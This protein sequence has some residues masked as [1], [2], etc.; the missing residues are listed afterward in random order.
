MLGSSGHDDLADSTVTGVEDMVPFGLQKLCCLMNSAVDHN[1]GPAI[2]VAWEQFCED[3]SS[4]RS[5]FGGFDDG[6]AARCNGAH[7]WTDGQE[8][9]IVPWRDD[10]GGT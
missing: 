6:C 5:D 1:V 2:Q 8:E 3:L 9:W 10:E 4:V 7:Q